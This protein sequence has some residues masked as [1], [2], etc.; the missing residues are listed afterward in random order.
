MISNLIDQPARAEEDSLNMKAYGAA[1][2]E[3]IANAQSPLTIALQGEW[4]S[5]KTSLMN[6]LEERLVKN[7]GS[8][9]FGVWINTWQYALLADPEEAILKILAGIVSQ[10]SKVAGTGDEERGRVLKKV[11]AVSWSVV[12]QVVAKQTGVDGNKV[13]AEWNAGEEAAGAPGVEELKNAIKSLV[14]KALAKEKGKRGF[15]FFIDDLDRIDPPVAVQILELLKNIFDLEHCIF[16]LAIDYGVVVKGLNPKFG[17]MTAANEREFRSFFDKIIQLPFSM[18]VGAYKIDDFLV[19]SLEKIGYLD[20]EERKDAAMCRA[21]TDYALE[22]VGTNPRSLKRLVNSLSLIRLLIERT[23]TTADDGD[24]K[25]W[26]DVMFALVCLQIQYPRVY[27]ALRTEPD[28]PGWDEKS[29]QSMHLKE[30]PADEKKKLS[31]MAEFDEEWEQVLF[32]LCRGDAFLES[33]ALKISQTL[34]R[35]KARILAKFPE[36]ESGKV[37][38][39]VDR[40]LKLSAVTDVK[41]SGAEAG[42]ANGDFYRPTFLHALRESALELRWASGVN[43]WESRLENGAVLSSTRSRLQTTYDCALWS[44][45]G[46]NGGNGDFLTGIG[47]RIDPDGTGFVLRIGGEVWGNHPQEKYAGLDLAAEAAQ[48]DVAKAEEGVRGAWWAFNATGNCAHDGTH[49][50]WNAAIPFASLRELAGNMFSHHLRG[51]L[52][53]LAEALEP[54]LAHRKKRQ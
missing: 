1:L 8:P 10:I 51:S 28:F 44:G 45:K 12:S 38:E 17:E 16:V 41:P 37:G 14:E 48:A 22:S 54:L 13:K 19:G 29:A 35:V 40:L 32:R 52:A 24:F 53:K 43:A 4:G 30:L 5:G 46:E 33:R 9:Y 20:G 6:T 31:E 34:N 2:T 27:D 47:F 18:P 25:A 36:Q 7:P 21:L 23:V 15:L 3:F 49:L 42:A 50:W 39:V 26:K 11:W